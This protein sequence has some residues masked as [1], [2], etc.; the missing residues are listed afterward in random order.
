VASPLDVPF[1]GPVA[2]PGDANDDGCADFDDFLILLGTYNKC[3]G[4][5]DYDARA[6][7]NGDNCTDFDDFLILLAAPYNSCAV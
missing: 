3:L 7:F 1:G 5:V 6:D 4:D 2:H